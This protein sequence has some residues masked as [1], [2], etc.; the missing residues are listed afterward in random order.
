MAAGFIDE[1]PDLDD[2][3]FDLPVPVHGWGSLPDQYGRITP[4]E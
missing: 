3:E 4:D 2:D 1:A